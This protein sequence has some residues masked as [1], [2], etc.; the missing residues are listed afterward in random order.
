LP[1]RERELVQVKVEQ[2]KQYHVKMCSEHAEVV[3]HEIQEL[4]DE[5]RLVR[6]QKQ[7]DEDRYTSPTTL[8]VVGANVGIL[9]P[10]PQQNFSKTLFA[11]L[12]PGIVSRSAGVVALARHLP[13][14]THH[15]DVASSPATYESIIFLSYV[16]CY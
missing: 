10:R 3:R 1:V 9:G 14:S 16:E 8:D 7:V 15:V 2:S 13:A 12:C 6:H 5:P 4:E 11:I